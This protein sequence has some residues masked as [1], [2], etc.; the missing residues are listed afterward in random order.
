MNSPEI[1]LE[2]ANVDP[3]LR[4]P[5]SVQITYWISKNWFALFAV[6]YGIYIGL[7]FLAP[8]FMK[9]G[10]TAP[11]EAI[12]AAYSLVCHQLPDR[13]FYFFGQQSMYALPDVQSVWQ[14]TPNPI[15]LRKF[16]GNSEFGWKVAWSDRMISM[17]GSIWVAA[18]IW[19]ALR[20]HLKALPLWGLILF[21][22][23]MAIYGT[24]HFISDLGGIDQGFRYTN[25]W[26]AALTNNAYS[27]AFYAGNGSGS[28]N[29]WM[30]LITGTQFGIG[31]VWYGFPYIEEIFVGMRKQIELRLQAYSALTAETLRSLRSE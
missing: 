2:E 30:R 26:L 4:L 21:S 27:A 19:A 29:A 24:T 31:I 10:W 12:Y 3:R 20:K 28:F 7:P 6:L 25:D 13:S 11:A 22:L 18:L 15:V 1:A 23:P 8:I 9:L 5:R 14:E 16:I 17:Y